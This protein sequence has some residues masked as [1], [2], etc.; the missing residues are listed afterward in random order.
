MEHYHLLY[1]DGHWKILTD[2]IPRAL[3]VFDAREEA[4]DAIAVF[5]GGRAASLTIYTPDG[6]IEEERC[7][8]EAEEAPA[9]ELTV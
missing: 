4:L 6:S 7:Y 5:L 9:A 3:A 2:G 1:N 8:S